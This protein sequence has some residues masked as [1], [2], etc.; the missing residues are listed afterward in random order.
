MEAILDRPATSSARASNTRLWIPR[1]LGS[2]LILFLAV[3][4]AGKVLRWAPYVEGTAKVGYPDGTLVPM[5]LALLVSTLLYAIPRTAP[6]GALLLTAY[7]G[8]A[9]ATHVRMGQPFVF[10]IV[11]GMLLWSCLWLRDARVRAL[12]PLV[13]RPGAPA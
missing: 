10:P 3:D 9:T 4:G 2:L 7:L 6:L 11:L 8:G 1:A 12:L 13:T 5:G